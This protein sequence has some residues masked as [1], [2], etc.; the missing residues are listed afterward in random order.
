MLDF[1][2]NLFIALQKVKRSINQITS[3][4]S[5]LVSVHFQ[6]SVRLTIN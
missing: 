2:T 6:V 5:A 3:V 4:T 1:K